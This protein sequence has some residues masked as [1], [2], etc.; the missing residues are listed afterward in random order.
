MRIGLLVALT[1]FFADWQ[2][3]A[4]PEVE[5]EER[6]SGAIWSEGE[7]VSPNGGCRV[8]L[9]RHPGGFLA[10]TFKQGPTKS[11]DDVTGIAWV[12]GETLVYTVSPIYSP[13]PGV[14]S[15]NCHSHRVKRLVAPIRREDAHPKDYFQLQAV[16]KSRPITIYFYYAPDVD[17]ES[18]ANFESRAHLYQVYMDGTGFH[19]A[20]QPPK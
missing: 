19:K 3:A 15:Y 14:Y 8:E 12:S 4:T 2:I 1:L 10:L 17:R 5:P 6:A 16:S 9:K 13:Q 18:F 20:N 11:I 7:F